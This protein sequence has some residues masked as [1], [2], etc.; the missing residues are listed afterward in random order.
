VSGESYRGEWLD[1]RP[2]GRGTYRYANGEYFVGDFKLG[3][4]HGVGVMYRA[5]SRVKESG[6]WDSDKLT[7]MFEIHTESSKG[8]DSG[9]VLS[10]VSLVTRCLQKGLKPG[11][12]TF[13]KCIAE[14]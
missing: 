1:N 5:D 2:H 7:Q 14:E 6:R 8:S 11:T 13:S 3:R 10:G 9:K 12:P 4:R